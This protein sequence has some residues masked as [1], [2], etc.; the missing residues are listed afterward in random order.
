[1]RARL[2]LVGLLLAWPGPRS[3]ASEDAGSR[4]GPQAL[5]GQPAPLF[6]LRTLNPDVGGPRFVMRDYVGDT[7]RSPKR[8]V[9]LDF[10]ASWCVPC[11]AELAELKT[12]ATRLERAGVAVAVIVI[13]DTKEGIETMRR[14]VV[15]ELELPF[16][17]V[18]DR[19]Q[20]LARRYQVGAL[21]LSVVVD[22]GGI[23]RA[24]EVGFTPG[25]L[26]RLEEAIGLEP[27]G[28]P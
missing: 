26:A 24:V 7:A 10:A 12:R 6:I 21:P 27:S 3:A 13:D 20:V 28:E 18:S 8:R 14:L 25:G 19:F 22:E 2:A 17:V 4:P 5:L 15:D 11:R 16:P 23:V 9:L 1:M